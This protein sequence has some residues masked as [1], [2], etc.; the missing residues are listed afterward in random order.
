M[1]QHR[2]STESASSPPACQ[3]ASGEWGENPRQTTPFSPSCP[4]GSATLVAAS[5]S[6]GAVPGHHGMEELLR[7]RRWPP[8]N[9][10]TSVFGMLI[11]S[12]LVTQNDWLASAPPSPPGSSCCTQ[13][14]KPPDLEPSRV[15]LREPALGFDRPYFHSGGS[16]FPESSAQL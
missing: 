12:P 9:T 2:Q 13:H 11:V 16:G 6:D 1:L 14:G 4:A 5:P 15:W 8:P 3:A 10:T 7:L